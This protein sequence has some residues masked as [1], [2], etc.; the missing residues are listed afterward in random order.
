MLNKFVGAVKLALCAT[1]TDRRGYSG[2]FSHRGSHYSS[3]P[4][5]GRLRHQ[6][7][8]RWEF[9]HCTKYVGSYFS[10]TIYS[11]TNNSL[12]NSLSLHVLSLHCIYVLGYGNV[13]FC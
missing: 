1:D 9:V 13:L 3:P 11:V 7:L 4:R 12:T 2:Q 8:G 10:K 5:G 6:I